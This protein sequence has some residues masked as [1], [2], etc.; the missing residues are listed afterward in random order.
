MKK[1]WF[2]FLTLASACLLVLSMTVNSQSSRQ[3]DKRISPA[4]KIAGTDWAVPVNI[5]NTG[6]PSESPALSLDDK[7][8]AYV[9]WVDWTGGYA[10]N[11]M[12]NTNESGTWG[13]STKISPLLYTDIDDVGFPTI[14]AYPDGG[15]AYVGYHD[16][17]FW[18]GAMTI[19]CWE[20]SNAKFP[21][22]YEMISGD[23]PSSSYVT[24]AVSPTDKFL[25][26][27]FMTDLNDLFS[28]VINY[29]DPNTKQW[30]GSAQVPVNVLGS[31]YLP[32]LW[33]D[34]KGTAHLV[35][36]SR[37]AG[38]IVWYSKNTTP[39]NANT[40]TS[41]VQISPTTGLDWTYPK[42]TA[43]ADGEAYVVWHDVTSGNSEVYLRRTVNGQ[44]QSA[45]NI[46]L[47]PDLSET[48]SVA[49]NPTT[50][51]LYIVWHENVGASNWEVLGKTYEIERASGIKKWS[52]II[53]FTNSPYHSGE[54]CIRVAPNGDIHL[55]YFDQRGPLWEDRDIFYTFKLKIR[56]FPPT[57]VALQTSINKILFYSEKINAITFAKN[58]E[59]D[60]SNLAS[61]KLYR[62]KAEET[63][64]QF[65]LLTTLNTS[66]FK[67]DDRK[68]PLTQNY[69]YAL[70]AVDKD[71]NESAKT[72]AITEK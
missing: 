17:L 31:S 13:T 71:G 36:I 42:V 21:S 41:P 29:R 6:L 12:F 7:G 16:G 52:N 34:L 67:Y 27:V 46:S 53:N 10:R 65:Q 64:E 22:T 70:S 26:A 11:M 2:L 68:L 18:R 25:Y 19:L 3:I 45:E 43:D 5:S 1:R 63:D 24:L 4:S 32:H 54:A 38:A 14:S 28:L 49:V 61:Y 69:A 20:Y 37:P 55:V 40:W 59:N 35:Y 66:T 39:K 62:R 51:E 33:I 15:R 50:K 30:A 57:A 9:T 58:S 8:K 60:D 56:V 23:A 48:A 72:A 47:T 44:F